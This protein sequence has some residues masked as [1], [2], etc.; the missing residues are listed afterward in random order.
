MSRQ[1]VLLQKAAEAASAASSAAQ[2]AQ[3]SAGA[4]QQATQDLARCLL[5]TKTA[6][7]HAASLLQQQKGGDPAAAEVLKVDI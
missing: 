1:G 7:L 6:E 3:Q 2:D 5:L 4:A